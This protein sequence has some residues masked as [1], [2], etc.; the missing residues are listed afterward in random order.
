MGLYRRGRIWW[1]AYS[2]NHRKINESAHTSNRRLAQRAL[3]KRNGEIAEGRLNLPRSGT[4]PRLEEYLEQFLSTVSEVSTQKR[5]RSSATKL[6]AFLGKPRISDI[7]ADQIDEFIKQ[8][9]VEGARPATI[10]RDLAVLRIILNL[11]Q[12]R[13]YITLNPFHQIQLLN[14]ENS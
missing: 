6:V 12:K 9:Q 13:R 7:S 1:M 5:Y 8:R 2:V 11:A 10:N 3:D 14:P 4:T